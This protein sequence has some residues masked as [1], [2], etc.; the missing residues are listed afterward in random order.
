M[1]QK[2]EKI[3]INQS[4]GTTKWKISSVLGNCLLSRKKDK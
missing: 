2:L 3:R 4:E 1:R